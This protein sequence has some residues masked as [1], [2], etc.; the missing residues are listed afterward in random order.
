MM[1]TSIH[2]LRQFRKQPIQLNRQKNQPYQGSTKSEAYHPETAHD[3]L[4]KCIFGALD[5]IISAI[6]DRSEQPALKK[7]RNIEERLL[8]AINKANSSKKWKV[9]EA[10]LLE[11]FDHIQLESELDIIPAI[12][13]QSAP[14]NFREICKTFQD[15]DEEKRRMIKDIWTFIR[16]VLTSGA[17]SATPERFFSMQRKIKTWLNSTIGQKNITLCQF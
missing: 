11:D 2:F 10:N 15:M 3:Y 17:T 8:N 13:K 6:N 9:L 12:F 14:V 7:F 1:K 5:A 4:N 16:I